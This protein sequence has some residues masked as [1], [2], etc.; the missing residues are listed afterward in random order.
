MFL[1]QVRISKH[2][3]LTL[4]SLKPASLHPTFE[5]AGIWSFFLGLLILAGT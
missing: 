2:V 3:L 5:Q 1:S 4:C